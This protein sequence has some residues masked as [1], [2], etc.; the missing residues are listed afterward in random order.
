MVWALVLASW[1]N[2][3]SPVLFPL[4]IF[5]AGYTDIFRGVPVILTIYLVGFGIPALKLVT[6]SFHFLGLGGNWNSPYLWGPVA[7]VLSYSAYVAEVLRAGIEGVHE[8]QRAGARSLGLS[9]GQTMRF[10]VLP[11]AG[12]RVIPALMNDFLSLQKDVA[13]LSILGV[14][15]VFRRAQSLKDLHFNYTPFV[16]AAVIFLALTIPETRLVDWYSSRQR[17]RTGGSVIS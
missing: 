4:R 10:V 1:R 2:T 5:A 17:S 6:G 13:L 12:R 8:S 11:Q 15:E 3:R 9:Q 14:I 16:A 7:L